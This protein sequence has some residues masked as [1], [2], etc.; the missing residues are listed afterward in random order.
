MPTSRP[1][2]LYLDL[3]KKCLIRSMFPEEYRPLL[4]PGSG[5]SRRQVA[6]HAYLGRFLARL[7]VGLYRK[8]RVDPLRRSEGRDWPAEAETMIGL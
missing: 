1:A 8:V 4:Q 2:D 7:N 6:L 3:I 5:H